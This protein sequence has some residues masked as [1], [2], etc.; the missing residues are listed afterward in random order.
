MVFGDPITLVKN[1]RS[2]SLHIGGMLHSC[3]L[4]ASAGTPCIALAYDIKHAGFFE[5]IGLPNFCFDAIDL[6]PDRIVD[7]AVEALSNQAELRQIIFS[8]RERYQ[9][10]LDQFVRDSIAL[11]SRAT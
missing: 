3:I 4:A 5:I 7:A 9:S 11:I 2:L 6:K 1:Y 10:R 8:R